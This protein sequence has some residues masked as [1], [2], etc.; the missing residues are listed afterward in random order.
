MKK[1]DQVVL[2]QGGLDLMSQPLKVAPGFCIGA[3]NYEPQDEGYRRR[4][5]YER[6][7]GRPSPSK[8]SY[9]IMKYDTGSVALNAGAL[10][11]GVASNATA[12]VLHDATIVTGSLA[13]GDAT[14]EVVLRDVIGA[15]E[16]AEELQVSGSEVAHCDGEP[17]E[18]GAETDELSHSY[19][20]EAI[21]A[22]REVIQ[23]VPGS[24]P[25]LGVCTYKGEIIAFRNHASEAMAQMFKATETGW[26][27][28]SFG[29]TLD[30]NTGAI[31]E[32]EEG[33]LITGGTSGATATIERVVRQSGSWSGDAKGYLVISGISG[34]FQASETFTGSTSGAT[35]V[36]L[37]PS[38]EI[39]LPKGGKYRTKV[40]NF[41]GAANLKRLYGCNGVGQAFEWDGAVLAP[42][43][44]GIP[45]EQEKPLFISV[46]SN[47]LLLGYTGGALQNSGTGKPLSFSA[48]DGAGEFSLG[49]DITGLKSSSKTA[50]I[51]TGRNKIA[52]LTG[53]DVSDLDLKDISEDSGAV[54]DTL[55]TV[56]SPYFLDDRGIRSLTAA[57]TFGDWSIAT[58]TKLVSKWFQGKRKGSIPAI[59]SLRVKAAGQYR[60]FFSDRTGMTLYFGRGK[61]E[62]MP[63]LLRFTPTC[64]HSGEDAEGNEVLFAGGADGYVYQL[65]SGTSDDGAPVE[66]YLR[67]AFMNQGTPNQNKRYHCAF[68]DVTDAGPTNIISYTADF[69]FSHP[70]Q[71]GSQEETTTI[72]GGGGFWD[73]AYWDQFYWDAMIQGQAVADLD[74]LG[75]NISFVVMSDATYEEPHTLAS[76]TIF[77]SSRGRKKR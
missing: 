6:L 9:W 46:H 23:A 24:G 13:G 39:T 3:Q 26:V 77:Y 59:G 67:L 5:G 54:A 8:A 44:S 69:D 55:E 11:T 30:F 76:L 31:A 64:L 74:G 28:Q 22:R 72:H 36:A 17:I 2:L 25:V 66:A 60:I 56:G 51:V 73:T 10:I 20:I 49:D 48:L 33:D 62:C 15:F 50:T 41:Y 68:L 71:P 40:H 1:R 61:P 29:H 16:D 57:Q 53:S 70:D 65:D 58:E 32:F 27:L 42:I 45:A 75:T 18:F 14:G 7:D 35:A 12:R 38:Q 63:F 34:S 43:R 37:G 19:K 4:G 52:Y 47:H 21:E